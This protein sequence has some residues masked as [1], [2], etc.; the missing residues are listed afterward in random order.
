MT[1]PRTGGKPAAAPRPGR[2]VRLPPHLAAAALALLWAYAVFR[3][4]LTRTGVQFVPPLL[5]ILLV[6]V[7][8]LAGTGRAGP[9]YAGIALART[10][11]TA[12]ALAGA[13]LLAEALAP[14][15]GTASVDPDGAFGTILMT[16]VCLLVLAAVLALISVGLYLLYRVLAALLRLVSGRNGRLNDA[17]TLAGAVLLLAAASVEGLPW[18]YS[19]DGRGAARSSH[20][21]DAPPAAVWRAMGTATSPAF[22]LPPVLRSLPRP[23]AVTTDEG[24]G[25]GARRVVRFRGREGAGDLSL[26][27]TERTPTRVRLAVLSDTG[28]VANWVALRAITYEVTPRPGGTVLTVGVEY[29]SL[30]APA[31]V[32]VPMVDGAAWLAADVLAR[33]TAARAAG[34]AFQRRRD[35]PRGGGTR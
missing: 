2:V 14:M 35:A 34:A 20:V 4:D 5:V 16:L 15:P 17:G 7:A 11:R 23:V 12:L 32:F 10:A 31:W 3:S 8:W 24:V 1:A 25:L 21:L 27:V 28:P 19:F 22:P 29:D 13:V 18:A 9:G 30:L 6:H 26:R 33:D